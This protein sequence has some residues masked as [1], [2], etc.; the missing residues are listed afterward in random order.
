MFL[1]IE[2]HGF[3]NINPPLTTKP[4]D[5]RYTAIYKILSREKMTDRSHRN[6]FV[7]TFYQLFY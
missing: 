5:C 4:F 7:L 3:Y 2:V 1:R 6:R